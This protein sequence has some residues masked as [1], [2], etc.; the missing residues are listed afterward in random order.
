M[1]SSKSF[2]AAGNS[3]QSDTENSASDH[4][5]QPETTKKPAPVK[6]LAALAKARQARKEKAEAAKK[7]KEE[8]KKK[9]EEA[10]K[11]VSSLRKPKEPMPTPSVPI[12][13]PSASDMMAMIAKLNEKLEKKTK[14]KVIIQSDTSSEDEVI[15]RKPNRK[16]IVPAVD[17]EFEQWK[18]D[19]EKRQMEEMNKQK[20]MQMKVDLKKLFSRY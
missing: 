2:V 1:N 11:I 18:A 14:K 10:V 20:E 9:K 5:I 6:A 19:K 17:P 3:P 7:E 4:E 8:I 16:S 15:V 12:E 13:Q